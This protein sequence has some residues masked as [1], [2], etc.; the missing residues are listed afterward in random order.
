[1]LVL[2][3]VLDSSDTLQLSKAASFTSSDRNLLR[4]SACTTS[5][6]MNTC[7]LP[8]QPP[9]DGSYSSQ[10]RLQLS[11]LQI[12]AEVHICPVRVA[13]VEPSFGLVQE[14]TGL[15]LR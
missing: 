8:E 7:I 1:M 12:K 15:T 14:V 3:R 13:S 6:I 5:A 11:N 2:L 10:P 4:W 9:V